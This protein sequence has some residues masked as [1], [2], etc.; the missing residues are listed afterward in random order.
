MSLDVPAKNNDDH[1]VPCRVMYFGLPPSYPSERAMNNMTLSEV[2]QT[3]KY[4]RVGYST[5]PL[6]VLLYGNPVNPPLYFL[7]LL[8]G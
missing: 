2:T 8:S 4:R 5:S 1:P 7:T 6:R 3:S